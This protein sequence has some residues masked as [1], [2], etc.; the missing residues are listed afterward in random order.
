MRSPRPKQLIETAGPEP[1]TPLE[2]VRLQVGKVVGT[3]GVHGELR[4]QLT[5]DDPEHLATVRSMFLGEEH[6]PRRVLSFRM[7]GDRALVRLEGIATPEEGRRYAGLPLRI[8]GRDARPLAPGEFYLYQLVGLRV[9]D[10]SG[11]EIGRVT[12]VLET[13]ANDVLVVT[14]AAGREHLFPHHADVVLDVRPAEGIMVVRPLIYYGEDS[15]P[16]RESKL[17]R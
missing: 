9:L 10:E 14:D 7:H 3:H 11:T 6:Q 2:S 17:E 12:D 8:S 13:G 5:T 15:E 1:S 16:E 4:V